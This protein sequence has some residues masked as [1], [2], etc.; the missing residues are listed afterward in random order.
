MPPI[1][2]ATKEKVREYVKECAD[3]GKY[4]E[5]NAESI[6]H[7]L[8]NGRIISAKDIV[9]DEDG[10]IVRIKGTEVVDGVL[11]LKEKK[12]VLKATPLPDNTPIPFVEKLKAQRKVVVL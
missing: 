5:D 9:Y 2:Q 6:I 8:E 3:E 1:N 10:A 11:L 7:L 4:W 12:K